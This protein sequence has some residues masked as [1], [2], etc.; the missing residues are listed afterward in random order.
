MVVLLVVD[1]DIFAGSGMSMCMVMGKRNSVL[2]YMTG[3]GRGS[4][5]TLEG[6]V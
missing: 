3:P 2:A 4:G 5:P 6:E 1:E